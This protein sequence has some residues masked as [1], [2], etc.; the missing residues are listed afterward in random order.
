MINNNN[1]DGYYVGSS[2]I[3]INVVI[4]IMDL[5]SLITIYFLWLPVSRKKNPS[6]ALRLYTFVLAMTLR[7]VASNPLGLKIRPELDGRTPLQGQWLSSIWIL[8]YT[9]LS[10][11]G[12]DQTSQYT[13]SEYWRA[14]TAAHKLFSCIDTLMSQTLFSS[15]LCFLG[16][17]LN[18]TQW[19]GLS[20]GVLGNVLFCYHYS[21][22]YSDP[23]R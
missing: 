16:M 18:Y 20:F 9:M 15:F 7:R 8:Q 14:E 12:P 2:K 23:K 22:R 6:A 11:E 3:I 5:I 13:P 10:H 1:T 4:I 19:W 21:Q 17:I